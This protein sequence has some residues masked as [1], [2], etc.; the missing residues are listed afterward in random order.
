MRSTVAV[1]LAIILIAFGLTL[2]G[3][4]GGDKQPSDAEVSREALFTEINQQRA[5][6]KVATL[7]RNA[8]LDEAAQ[9]HVENLARQDKLGDK[10]NPHVLD[11][12]SAVDRIK[13]A[14]YNAAGYGENIALQM[15]VKN[16][17]KTVA[18]AVAFWMTSD[19]HRRNILEPMFTET[20]VG[21]ARSK[22]GKWF[23]CQVFGDPADKK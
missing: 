16:P 18:A 12:K 1:L 21:A 17:K 14:G 13:A 3:Q 5:K 8:K 19:G 20:G 9:K 4:A 22:S 2:P 15:D 11:G 23:Y 6:Q 10:G 7:K